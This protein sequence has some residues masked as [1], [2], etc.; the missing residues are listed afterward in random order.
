MAKRSRRWFGRRELPQEPG[1]GQRR[2]IALEVEIAGRA[3]REI[4]LARLPVVIGRGRDCDVRLDAARLAP[5]HVRI[6]LGDGQL[7]VV[8][9]GGAVRIDGLA[10]AGPTRA[11]V[12]ASITAGDAT[13]HVHVENRYSFP[14][15]RKHAF[16]PPAFEVAEPAPVWRATLAEDPIEQGFVAH[17]RE[18]P[19]DGTTR[20]VYADWLEERGETG[21]AELV[22]HEGWPD[23]AL[24]ATSAWRAIVAPA[25]IHGCSRS[26]CPAWWHALYPS[27]DERR[28]VC[29]QCARGV[30]FW[31][32]GD[33][34]R[35]RA[36]RDEPF[37]LDVDLAHRYL[38]APRL[39]A[40]L[41]R[42]VDSTWL[43]ERRHPTSPPAWIVE[44]PGER[45]IQEIYAVHL[46]ERLLKIHY[47]GNDAGPIHLSQ[48][49][50]YTSA[51]LDAV[52]L[53]DA[54]ISIGSP[55][56]S[57]ICHPSASA[58]PDEDLLCAWRPLSPA[59]RKPTSPA[60]PIRSSAKRD[61]AS[62][63]SR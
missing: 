9:L 22:Q 33:D 58:T 55:R 48:P 21:R 25:P 37:V 42:T 46:D 50:R 30:R 61:G 38:D 10:I 34:P 13:L 59:Y 14:P 5:T 28:R 29:A 60:K 51:E 54:T 18:A 1:P 62:A 19:G 6:D 53:D 15:P 35:A 43:V 11:S 4:E 31:G 20:M 23:A 8:P 36:G 2:I 17:L 49:P 41:R 24:L 40:I 16:H 45:I 12:A 32:A 52:G 57:T 47:G 63:C 3:R 7:D 26:E 44:L 27:D 39:D 56:P